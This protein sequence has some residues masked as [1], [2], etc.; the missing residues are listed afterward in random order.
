MKQ[1]ELNGWIKRVE[2]K[3]ANVQKRAAPARGRNRPG[4]ATAF[5]AAA[6]NGKPVSGR[7]NANST[8]TN[9]PP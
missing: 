2:E 6:K 7:P 9:P 1:E 3:I 5:S 4:A 8:A